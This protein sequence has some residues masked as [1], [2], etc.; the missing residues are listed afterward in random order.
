[1]MFEIQNDEI[2]WIIYSYIFSIFAQ[3]LCASYTISFFYHTFYV[4][5]YGDVQW[6]CFLIDFIVIVEH[7][8]WSNKAVDITC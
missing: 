3:F 5:M 1:M 2:V 6:S 7:H 4:Y 8:K